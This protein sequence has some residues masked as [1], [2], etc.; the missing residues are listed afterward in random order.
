[1]THRYTVLGAGRQGVSA[2]YDL[3][4]F[5]EASEVI[6]GDLDLS[7]AEKGANILN[8]LLGKSIVKPVMVDANDPEKLE[9]I[10]REATSV[11]SCVP[12]DFNLQIMKAAINTKTNMCDLGGHTQTVLKQLEH[13]EEAKKK[14]ISVVPDCGMGPG[15]NISLAVYAMSQLDKSKEV[16]IWDGGL[17]QDPK[18]PWNYELTFNIGGLT[19]EYYGSAYFLRDGKITEVPCFE[20]Y[21]QLGFPPPLNKLEAFVTSGGLSTMPWTFEGKLDRLEN[22]TLRYP[23]HHRQFKAFA[24]L[25]LLELEPVQVGDVEVIP[26]DVFHKLLEPKIVQPDIR[27]IAVIRVLCRG[28]HEGKKAEVTVELIDKFD[29]ATKL[30]AMQRLTGWHAS[31]VAILCAQ[32]RIPKGVVSVENILG[33]LIVTEA[34]KRGFGIDE[35]LKFVD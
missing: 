18:P 8:E 6:L 24:E 34:R 16:Y 5:G 17:P 19:N 13:N 15:M 21:E 9:E 35:H 27:D 31:I 2:A 25:G 28:A 1:M 30:T 11:I 32:N 33:D 7:Y 10:M 4:K 3:A 14:E 23:G 22:K 12:Y 20:G 29:E 26:R